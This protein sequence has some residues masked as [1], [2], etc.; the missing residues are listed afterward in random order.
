MALEGVRIGFIGGGAMAEALAGGLIGAG[1]PR[2]RVRAAEPAPDRRAHLEQQLGIGTL[3]DNA[4]LVEQTVGQDRSSPFMQE[5]GR[6]L[7]WIYGK[8]A[9]GFTKLFEWSLIVDDNLRTML[10]QVACQS[11]PLAGYADHQNFLA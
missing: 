8:Y 10:G 3:S 6:A 5:Y 9:Q 7:E 4:E 2:D 11:D 1:T